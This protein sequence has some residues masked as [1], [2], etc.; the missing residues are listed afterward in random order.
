[1]HKRAF[2]ESFVFNFGCG[3][4]FISLARTL[5]QSD[6]MRVLYVLVIALIAVFAMPVVHAALGVDISAQTWSA[7]LFPFLPSLPN[8]AH[9]VHSLTTF[10]LFG[11]LRAFLSRFMLDPISSPHL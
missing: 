2:A 11:N 8:P 9:H 1:M 4:S 6:T 10:F 5:R 3:D 7:S